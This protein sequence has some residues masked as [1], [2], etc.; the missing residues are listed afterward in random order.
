MKT[1]IGRSLYPNL[2]YDELAE[3]LFKDEIHRIPMAKTAMPE[4]LNGAA[5]FLAS[6]AS[7]YMT[8]HILYI[9]GGQMAH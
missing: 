2:N 5:V 3:K 1:D 7:D 4:D 8:G 9:D 6:R